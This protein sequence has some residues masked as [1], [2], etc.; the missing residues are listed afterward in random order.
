[1][2][3]G[4][5]SG[6]NYNLTY[7]MG[8]I[9]PGPYGDYA[10]SNYFIGAGFQYIYQIGEFEFSI[11][12]IDL[13]LGILTPTAH[14]TADNQLTISTRGAGGYT[15]YAYEQHPLEL[16]GGG[17]QIP[18][19]TCDTG[20]CD[21]TEAKPWT[22]QTVP[23]FGFNIAGDNVSSDFTSS[24]PDCTSDTECFRQFADNSASPSE[25]MQTVMASDSIAEDES[26]TVTYKAGISGTQTSGHYQTN[27]VY[28]A[29]PGY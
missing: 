28:V 3:S 26:A 29:V 12:D 11:S 8:Q 18:D 10:S 9:A 16:V 20:S 5:R 24:D 7:T 17:D 15:V 13:D 14:N 22:V 2:G 4:E 25:S 19:T 21:E 1:M 6:T 27:I 23:G